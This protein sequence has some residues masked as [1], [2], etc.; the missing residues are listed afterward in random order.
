[1]KST[2]LSLAIF[3]ICASCSNPFDCS[4]DLRYEVTGSAESVNI[5]Y[6]NLNGGISQLSGRQLPWSVTLTADPMDFVFLSATNTGETGSV[7]V[8][9]FDDGDV[10]KRAT[11]EG[12]HV[13]ASVSGNLE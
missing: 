12:A 11:S 6:E 8:T 5:T 7:T 4:I 10:F 9:I 2:I 3:C 13:T 1:M